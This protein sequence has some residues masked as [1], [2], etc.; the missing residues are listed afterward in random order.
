[1][2]RTEQKLA[3]L[4]IPR[5]A[6]GKYM[7]ILTPQQ[8]R[9]LRSDFAYRQDAVYETDYNPLR[10]SYIKTLGNVELYASTTNPVDTSTVSG[11][12]INH[13]IAFGPGHVGYAQSGPARVAASTDD[14]YGEQVKVIWL[15]YEGFSVLDSRMAV[16]VHSN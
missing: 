15:A 12:S 14:N 9:Q 6:N 16:S 1:V 5:F 4:N 8:A 13:A 11:V 3:D 2:Y 10:N 7:M